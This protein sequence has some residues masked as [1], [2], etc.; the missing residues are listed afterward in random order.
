MTSHV[1]ITTDTSTEFRAPV[2]G[3][4]LAAPRRLHKLRSDAALAERFAAGDESAFAVLYERHRAGVF[5]VCVGVLGAGHDAED[6]VQESFAALA[7]TLRTSPP[8]ELRPW[9][10]R[11]ARNAAIDVARGRRRTLATDQLPELAAAPQGS[12]PEFDTVIAGIRELPENQRTALLM[13][14]LGGHSYLEI[15]TLLE[16]DEEAVRGLIA[17]ARVGLRAYREASDLPCAA[18]RAAIE[19]EPDG[20]RHNRTVRRHLRGCASCRSYRRALRGDAKALRSIVPAHAGAVAGGSALAGGLAAKGA[21]VGVGMTQVTAACAASVCAVGGMVLLYPHHGAIPLR[22]RDPGVHLARARARH[23]SARATRAVQRQAPA[24][25][26]NS[27]AD[28]R[29]VTSAHIAGGYALAAR[30]TAAHRTSRGGSTHSRTGSTQAR[31]RRSSSAATPVH[32][33]L[34]ATGATPVTPVNGTGASSSAAGAGGTGNT[35]RYGGSSRGAQSGGWSGHGYS[36]GSSTATGGF[37][38][39]G[40]VTHSY[41][42]GSGNAGSGS[43]GAGTRSSGWSGRHFGSGSSGWSGH[44]SRGGS[45]GSGR[46]SREAGSGSSGWSGRHSRGGSG[47]ARGGSSEP[48]TGRGDGEP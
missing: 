39:R 47:G 48:G 33:R 23:Q 27:T 37:T 44:H 31:S 26:S 25:S 11:V 8:R 17:R 20:R 34:Q 9:L 6:A 46:G 14:E 29:L 19:A 22:S 1:T 35:G 43:G 4:T 3:P 28:T 24:T 15:A 18:A 16:V 42:D 40:Y 5:A 45:S 21:L 30:R 32:A 7:Q 13:R 41:N 36:G 12:S 10:A 38:G 2:A